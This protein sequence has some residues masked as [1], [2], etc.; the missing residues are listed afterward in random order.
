MSTLTHGMDVEGVRNLAKK[1]RSNAEKIEKI[2][3]DTSK[4][5]EQV[6]WKGKDHDKFKSDWNGQHK[7]ALKKAVTD[8]KDTAKAIDKQVKEQEEASS[9]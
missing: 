6:A 8:L 3:Q 1:M 9:K 2:V 7:S 4:D 5:L